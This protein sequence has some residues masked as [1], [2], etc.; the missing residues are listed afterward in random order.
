MSEVSIQEKARLKAKEI[1][2]DQLDTRMY[3]Y[4]N[5]KHVKDVREGVVELAES[6]QLTDEEKRALEIAA[7]M[8]DIG[9]L[10]GNENHEEKSA[11]TTAEFLRQEGVS[12]EEIQTVMR[13]IMATKSGHEPKDLMEKIIRDADCSHVGTKSYFTRASLLK[14][15]LNLTQNK[16]LDEKS[17]LEENYRFLK[18]HKFYTSVAET[19]YNHRKRKNLMKV[20]GKLANL[21]DYEQS[22]SGIMTDEEDTDYFVPGKRADRGTETMFRV[23][24]RN[25]NNLSTIAD[26]K[27]NIM[28][29]INSIMLSIVLSTLAPKLDTNP[30][31]IA[32]TV[33]LA[34]V[35]VIAIIF[36]ILATRPKISSAPFTEERFLKRKV[37]ILFF[38]NFYK[39]SLKQF[40][41]GL[42]TLMNNEDM[43]YNNLTKDLYYLGLVL[44][45]KYKYL[46]VC[47]NFFAIGVV[48]AALAFFFA[49]AFFPT[50][51]SL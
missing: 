37:N 38:G 19:K 31:L 51:T 5:Y 43:L 15:E 9:Y 7:W 47:Y 13:L 17:W 3:L 6:Y 20:E 33:I 16:N 8:H 22:A 32:P 44:A 28:L 24:L 49:F 42:Q 23:T 12:D 40:E 50:S 36:A 4:H 26:N 30:N 18:R 41:W 34:V 39:L 14:D 35:C 11:E 10:N 21:V 1:L 45:R 27:A 2:Q 25:H 48:V 46:R 29:S